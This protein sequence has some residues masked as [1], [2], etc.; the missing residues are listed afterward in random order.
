VVSVT[1]LYGHI[2]LRLFQEQLNTIFKKKFPDRQ[3]TGQG[4]NE[5]FP[6]THEERGTRQQERKKSDTCSRGQNIVS[7]LAPSFSAT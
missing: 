1:D 3:I 4:S 2:R 5:E 7:A 6:N